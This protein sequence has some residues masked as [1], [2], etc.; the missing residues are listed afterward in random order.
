MSARG[1]RVIE[2]PDDEVRILFTNLAL[3]NAEQRMNKSVLAVARQLIDGQAGIT[4]V[5]HLLRAGMEAANRS[6][7]R[8]REAVSLADA[9]AV[10]DQVGLTTVIT[11]V[12]EAMTE[13]LMYRGEAGL[14]DG[15]ADPNG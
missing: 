1:E 11:A 4:E 2:T 3:A 15:G 6:N 10:M 5:A 13:V 12:L 8:R 9:Y 14:P 7:G